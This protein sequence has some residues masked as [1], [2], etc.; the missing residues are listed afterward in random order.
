MFDD[1]SDCEEDVVDGKRFCSSVSSFLSF[2]SI[3]SRVVF[4]DDDVV[5]VVNRLRNMARL[6][7]SVNAQ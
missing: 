1:D 7:R 6:Y 3:S 2:P 5:V 4:D